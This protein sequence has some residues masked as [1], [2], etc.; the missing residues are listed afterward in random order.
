MS[1]LFSSMGDSGGVTV[2][3]QQYEK[4]SGTDKDSLLSQGQVRRA[5][6]CPPGEGQSP[7]SLCDPAMLEGR[8]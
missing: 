4:P 7:W 3:C 1:F 5:A 2:H 6:S 8:C